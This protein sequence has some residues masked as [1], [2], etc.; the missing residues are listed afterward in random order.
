MLT[1]RTDWAEIEFAASEG[2]LHVN[3]GDRSSAATFHKSLPHDSLGQVNTHVINISAVNTERVTLRSSRKK[4]SGRYILSTVGSP[5]VVA[6]PR[7]NGQDVE[8]DSGGLAF[9]LKGLWLPLPHFP[10]DHS[11]KVQ[12]HTVYV[13]YRRMRYTL[14][15][16]DCSASP[17]TESFVRTVYPLSLTRLLLPVMLQVDSDAFDALIDCI[18]EGDFDTCE[19]VPAG[20]EDG[21]LVNPL[22][23]LAIN[24]AGPAR[25]YFLWSAPC[26]L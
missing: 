24:M 25:Y 3:N 23:G 1:Q 9:A 18:S 10:R 26:T 15:E 19:Q 22:G 14:R 6:V 12:H 7:S 13:F 8:N 17:N 21:F 5:Q 20:D 4:M 16:S 2:T 11:T